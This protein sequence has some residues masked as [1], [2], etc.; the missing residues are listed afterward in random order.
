MGGDMIKYVEWVIW[1]IVVMVYARIGY[2]LFMHFLNF[3][4]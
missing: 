2:S 4:F 3:W 1:L